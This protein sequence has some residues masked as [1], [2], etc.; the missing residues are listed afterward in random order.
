MSLGFFRE[1]EVGGAHES[2]EGSWAMTQSLGSEE[3]GG[4]G[5]AAE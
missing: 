3:G 5:G 1:I 4:K 2:G